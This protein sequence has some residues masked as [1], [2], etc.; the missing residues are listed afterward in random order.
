M[1]FGEHRLLTGLD[2]T[3]ARG[4]VVGLMGANGAG[5]S[6]LLRLCAGLLLPRAGSVRV[7]EIPAERARQRGWV[8]WSGS[9]EHAFQRRLSLGENLTLCA[10]LHGLRS[11]QRARRIREVAGML[12]IEEQLALPAERCSS[13]QRQ[14]AAVAR[15]LMTR[16]PLVL[17]DEP[18]RGIDAESALRL[19]R[20][21]RDALRESAV[22]WV[23]H[24][25]QEIESVADRV[26][27]LEKG[28]LHPQAPGSRTP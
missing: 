16:A 3:A 14:R 27:R 25:R 19:A 15:A 24:S 2:L 23:S 7:C 22:L 26:L 12:G 17:L 5:K 11:S 4:E 13:G 10:R 20:I 1:R 8:G 21:L 9:G 6:T 18:L 28:A